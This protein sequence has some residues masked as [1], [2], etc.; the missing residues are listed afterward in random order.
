MKKTIVSL[1]LAFLF[2]F[3]LESQISATLSEDLEP[4]EVLDRAD[5]IVLG[6]YD[7]SADPTCEDKIFCSL[8]F[9]VDQ[10]YRGKASTTMT[11]GI[12]RYDF[13]LVEEFQLNGGKILL[14]LEENG[15]VGYL[16]PVGGGHNGMIQTKDGEIY[17]EKQEKKEFYEEFLKE[18]NKTE[19]SSVFLY[20]ILGLVAT[21]IIYLVSKRKRGV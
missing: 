6:E 18:Q 5:V 8:K 2:I 13:G 15:R 11:A 12:D 1:V 16:T 20:I 19:N 21:V 4:E 9:D 17:H 14:F 7:F 10:T 3:Y